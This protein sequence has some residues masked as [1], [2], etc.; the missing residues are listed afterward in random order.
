MTAFG[1]K[2]TKFMMKLSTARAWILLAI[3]NDG[4]SLKLIFWRAD[5]INKAIPT[6]DELND[7]LGWLQSVGLITGVDSKYFRTNQG[8]KLIE[9]CDTGSK[10]IFDIWDC[11]DNSINMI[12]VSEFKL[13]QISEADYKYAYEEYNKEF[14]KTYEEL[15][16]KDGERPLLAKSGH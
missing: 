12:E 14:W 6:L 15:C 3:P 4:G 8:N 2:A 13:M 1:R 16:K 9:N 7:S 11:I 10:S 5:G